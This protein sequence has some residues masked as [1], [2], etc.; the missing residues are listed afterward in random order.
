MGVKTGK[1]IIQT[2]SPE[3]YAIQAAAKHDYVG[4]YHQEIK[5]RQEYNYPPFSQ[6]VRLVYTHTNNDRCRLAAEKMSRLILK[7][8]EGKGLSDLNLIG[9]MPAFSNRIRGRYRWQLIIR[10]ANP[11]QVLSELTLPQGWIVDV[12]PVGL[13]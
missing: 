6:L 12:D 2:Y 11:T 13:S 4:F 3:N 1:A 7:E 5:Y 9:P 10:G 8:K